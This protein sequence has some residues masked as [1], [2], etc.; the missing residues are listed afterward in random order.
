MPPPV[1]VRE[2]EIRKYACRHTAL[3]MAAATGVATD[4]PAAVKIVKLLV[5]KVTPDLHLI[6]T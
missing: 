3:M 1:R 6:Y 2:F 4:E 5:S